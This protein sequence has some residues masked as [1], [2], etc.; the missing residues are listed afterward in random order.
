MRRGLPVLAIALFLFAPVAEGDL[1]DRPAQP[2]PRERGN[3][4]CG[5]D[6]VAGV[7]RSRSTNRG[8]SYQ[9]TLHIHRVP[10]DRGAIR[11]TIGVLVWTGTGSPPPPCFEGQ[12]AYHIVQPALGT[13][14]GLRI[15]FRGQSFEIDRVHCG[16]P[17]SYYPD[18]FTGTID[19][20]TSTFRA[21]NNDGGVAVNFPEVFRRIRCQ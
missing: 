10:G 15:D 5:G 2:P 21:V 9:T 17:G 1:A 19:P 8:L 20:R 3:A 12:T 7:W 11:G 13:T 16:T 4:E 18:Q 6:R 14:N